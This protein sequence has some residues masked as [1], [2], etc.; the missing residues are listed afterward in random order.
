MDHQHAFAISRTLQ[1]GSKKVKFSF[2]FQHI[3]AKMVAWYKDRDFADI[4]ALSGH[5]P[6]ESYHELIQEHIKRCREGYYDYGSESFN[7]VFDNSTDAQVHFLSLL[8]G[9]DEE[10]AFALMLE[11]PTEVKAIIE[12]MTEE[13]Q[14]KMKAVQ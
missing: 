4:T 13:L 8:T 2:V 7:K 12:E 1:W 3:K 11:K 5:I 9:L 14:E 6:K 10:S